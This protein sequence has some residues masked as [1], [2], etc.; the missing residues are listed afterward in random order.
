MSF[1]RAATLLAGAHQACA[2]TQRCAPEMDDKAL[3]VDAHNTN[4]ATQRTHEEQIDGVKL[5]LRSSIRLTQTPREL[6]LGGFE[7]PEATL[8][9]VVPS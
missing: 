2:G 8:A 7:R 9:R 4:A 3:Q 5:Y 6:H 1:E